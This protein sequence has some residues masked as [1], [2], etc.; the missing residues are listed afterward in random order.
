MVLASCP[1]VAGRL[2]GVSA[3][4][5]ECSHSLQVRNDEGDPATADVGRR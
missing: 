1:A 3:G 5:A 2:K 4:T